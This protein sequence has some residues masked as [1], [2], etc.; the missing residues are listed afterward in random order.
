MDDIRLKIREDIK[1]R[2]DM[3]PRPPKR[4]GRLFSVFLALLLVISV[5]VAVYFFLQWRQAPKTAE[6]IAARQQAE[7][8]E[9]VGR[10]IV[11]PDDEAPTVATVSDPDKLKDQTFFQ[12]AKRRDIVLIYTKARKA[13][14]YDPVQNKILEVA[15]LNVS[16]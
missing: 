11:L 13:I 5:G 14:L 4:T 8:I 10:L 12:S 7:I 3:N 9:K 1:V 2:D 15:P 6:D 16:E